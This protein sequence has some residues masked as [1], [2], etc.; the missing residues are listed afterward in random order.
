M[1]TQLKDL[2]ALVALSDRLQGFLEDGYQIQLEYKSQDLYFYKL[3]HHNGNRIT[4][5]YNVITRT[6]SQSTNG[7]QTYE[8]KVCEP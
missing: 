6:I 1:S 7:Q 4:L 3:V 2:K 5:K 8:S